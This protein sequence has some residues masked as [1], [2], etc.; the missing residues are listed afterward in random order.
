M[1]VAP[2]YKALQKQQWANPSIVF[3]GQHYSENMCHDLFSEFDIH[4]IRHFRPLKSRSF[5]ERMGEIISSYTEILTE[6]PPH[7]VVVP[8]DVDVTVGAAMA[9]KR[10]QHHVVHL[11]AG[12]R[13]HDGNM[14]EEQNRKLVDSISDYLLAPSEDAYQNLIFH[15][16][17]D[18]L[19]VALVGNIMI[20]ALKQTLDRQRAQRLLAK[21]ELRERAF[22]VVTLHRPSNVDTEEALAKCCLILTDIA[23]RLPILFPMHPRTRAMLERSGLIERLESNP[24]IRLCEPLSYSDFVNLV[25]A[26]RLI[27]T[28]SGGIQEE[29]VVM[30]VP[31][32]TLRESTERPVTVVVGGNTLVSEE[33]V[34]AQV[35]W[36]LASESRPIASVPLWDGRTAERCAHIMRVQWLKMNGAQ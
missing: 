19:R 14:P 20:D 12:L 33:D 17:H 29:A 1:K 36:E 27:V 22:A 11:E 32:L 34:I 5:G 3:L 28:D 9:A 23:Q 13:S 15:E 26:S 25:S 24:A 2:L 7:I 35:D 31:C 6:D 10:R 30:K 8:G 16:G 18:H 21:Y 4:E